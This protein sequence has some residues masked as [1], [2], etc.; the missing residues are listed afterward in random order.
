MI[1]SIYDKIGSYSKN[2]D[3]FTRNIGYKLRKTIRLSDLYKRKIVMLKNTK[4]MKIFTYLD[5]K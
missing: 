2:G 1:D 3:I 5:I 4:T